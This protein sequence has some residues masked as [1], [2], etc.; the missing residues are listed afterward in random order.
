M[1]TDRGHLCVEA[2]VLGL[3]PVLGGQR[4][5][6]AAAAVALPREHGVRLRHRLRSRFRLLEVVRQLLE[7]TVRLL[8]VI[9]RFLEVSRRFLE[10]G[11]GLRL[12]EAVEAVAGL[13]GEHLVLVEVSSGEV[14]H[15]GAR[16]LLAARCWRLL[17]PLELR[18]PGEVTQNL[19]RQLLVSPEPLV[20][21]L[22]ALAANSA[23]VN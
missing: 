12:E 7:V 4:A 9:S 18:G 21:L 14:L 19:A 17:Q 13:V 11:V 20:S 1:C 3:V 16:P 23:S 15:Y 6:P 10:V 2:W 5:V 8:E 22:L